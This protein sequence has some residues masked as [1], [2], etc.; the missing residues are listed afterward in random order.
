MYNL[1]STDVVLL[2]DLI[3]HLKS[4]EAFLGG[5]HAA[6]STTRPLKIVISTGNVGFIS[7]RL[8]LLLGHFDYGKRGILDLTHTR[9]FTF[10]SLRRL[11]EDSGFAISETRGIP[12]PLAMVA[13]NSALVQFAVWLNRLLIGAAPSLFAYQILMVVR[14]LPTLDTLLEHAHASTAERTR[15][16]G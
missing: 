3:E 13:K 1:G 12:M 8:M 7:L 16:V 10:R 14:P 9:L 2:L 6:A 4:P 5:L 11:L 15:A